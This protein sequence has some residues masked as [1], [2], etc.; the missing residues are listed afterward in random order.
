MEKKE[1]NPKLIG[2]VAAIVLVAVVCIVAFFM[3]KGDDLTAITV[4]LLNC[5]GEVTLTDDAGNEKSML[6]DMS[7]YSGY[8][9][10]TGADG[11][12][13]LGL[14][15]TKMVTL[16]NNSK[17]GF[18][19]EKK[20]IKLD[21]KEGQL[22]FNVKEK[23]ADDESFDIETSTM[24]VGIRGTSGYVNAE[25]NEI[26]ITDGVV[27]IHGTN[28][29]TGGENSIKLYAG[30]KVKL[31]LDNTKEGSDS[32]IFSVQ[33]ATLEDLPDFAL[34]EIAEDEELAERVAEV[35]NVDVEELQEEARTIIEKRAEESTEEQDV[36][37]NVEVEVS[38]ETQ[39]ENEPDSTTSTTVAITHK[40]TI[41]IPNSSSGSYTID[42]GEAREG[43]T[44][45]ITA[46]KNDGYKFTG[47]SSEGGIV[48]FAD[49][50]AETTT[51]VMGSSDVTIIVNFTAIDYKISVTSSDSSMGTVEVSATTAHI[52]DTIT[53]TATPTTGYTL[54]EWSLESGKVNLKDANSTSTTFVV[55]TSDVSIKAVFSAIKY[56]VSVSSNDTDM[57][58]A[59]ASSSSGKIGDTITLTAVPKAGYKFSKWKVESGKVTLDDATAES[60]T[61]VI[62]T[63][64]VTIKAV[65]KAIDYTITVASEDTKMGTVETSK[66]TAHI[67]DSITITATPKSGYLFSE[68][69]VKSGG[70]TLKNASAKSTTFE[71]GT[72]NVKIVASFVL[73]DYAITVTSEDTSMGSVEASAQRGFTGDEV[74]LTATPQPGYK[75]N[76]W[77]VESGD[78]TIKDA[79][80]ASTSFVVGTKDITIKASFTI[81]DYTI[82][83]TSA[84]SS[85]GS[86]EASA[87]TGHIGD[88]I[89]L[90]ASPEPGYTLKEWKV[91][92]GGVTV[93]TNSVSESGTSTGTFTIGSADV[94]ITATFELREYTVSFSIS[95][96][97]YGTI[98][99]YSGDTSLGTSTT[100]SA[101][102]STQA[103]MGTELTVIV[104]PKY[105]C[106]FDYTSIIDGFSEF[107]PYTT[108]DEIYYQGIYIVG[109]SD[110]ST[111]IQ[112]DM[113][114]TSLNGT[115]LAN[116]F[117]SVQ[118]L[119]EVY[120]IQMVDMASTD[121]EVAP[122]FNVSV[123]LENDIYHLAGI[124]AIAFVGQGIQFFSYSEGD[125]L[126]TVPVMI[127]TDSE[128]KYFERKIVDGI[129]YYYVNLG[130]GY[131]VEE[132]GA[133]GTSSSSLYLVMSMDG[134]F[135]GEAYLTIYEPGTY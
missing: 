109:N 98:S 37:G 134:E 130:T 64:D 30:Q 85:M 61:F 83:V 57:G 87:T 32:V 102:V 103:T 79:S 26:T 56:K 118:D 65:F 40:I 120:R 47:W 104:K 116:E 53:I 24:V 114:S 4:R 14:D 39:T 71:V 36:P 29:V 18:E 131:I 133:L 48:V 122:Y 62:G 58:S 35:F 72:E 101:S 82:T 124:P 69:T 70:V 5:E 38:E 11:L 12:V 44:V 6:E 135:T 99:V 112:V 100:S 60:T 52:G 55:K 13:K 117:Y 94:N 119:G 9:L 108:D 90:T 107:E 25:D 78:V 96:T 23:L 19:K 89:T 127:K 128:D 76:K 80:S 54:S 27:E 84:D 111:E 121:G 81:I 10:T 126:I 97:S 106:S 1:L 16:N 63:K 17:L 91:N 59:K 20:N 51:F 50:T 66:S 46:M 73:N 123:T 7:L 110:S 15:D 74:T 22:Y 31:E 93:S 92:S 28:D 86:V 105:Y 115:D 113:K 67:G 21:L 95:N 132:E 88:T 45:T 75:F 42:A 129:T 34:K 125:N 77:T 3:L 33:E 41:S 2:A 8:G 49:A 43:D 68:W